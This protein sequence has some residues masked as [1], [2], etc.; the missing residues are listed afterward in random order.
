M[1]FIE[2]QQL[3]GTNTMC[4]L[5]EIREGAVCYC[6]SA[7][8]MMEIEEKLLAHNDLL[9]KNV[10]EKIFKIRAKAKENMQ[11]KIIETT[12]LNEEHE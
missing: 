8:N 12:G 9:N 6:Q 7:V 3:E 11:A 1:N 2:K 10:K 5:Y 4:R